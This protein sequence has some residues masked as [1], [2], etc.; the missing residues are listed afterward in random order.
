MLYSFASK[1][2]PNMCCH[3]HF[4]SHKYDCSV[5]TASV[6]NLWS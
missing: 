6:T 1:S 4:Y 2:E 5:E 3:I